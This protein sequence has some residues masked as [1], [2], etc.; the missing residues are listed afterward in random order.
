MLL[1][2]NT[3]EAADLTPATQRLSSRERLGKYSGCNVTS[4]ERER[5]IRDRERHTD[6]VRGWDNKVSGV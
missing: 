1:A 3:E 2:H 4:S 5:E 6:V